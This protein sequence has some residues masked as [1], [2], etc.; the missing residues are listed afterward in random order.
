MFKK[1][2]V[3]LTSLY[4][5]IIMLVSLSF[6]LVIYSGINR[7]LSRIEILE[8]VR[9]HRLQALGLIPENEPS[10]PEIRARI[11]LTLG[12]V[13]LAILGISGLAGY[14]LAGK[15]LEPIEKM[16]EEQ[17]EFVSNASHELRTPL[18]ALKSEIEVSLRDKKMKMP[19]A[20][21][22]L[23]SNLEE[24]NKIQRLTNYLLS[25]NKYQSEISNLPFKNL[26]L[27]E[28]AQKAIKRVEPLAEVKEIRIAK[29]LERAIVN[30]NED[31]L[32]ELATILLDNAIKYSYKKGVVVVRAKKEKGQAVLEVEDNGVGIKKK[33]IPFIFDRFYRA[34]TSRSK[35]KIDGYGLGLS[36]AKNIVDLHVGKIE[37]RSKENK[38]T[39]FQVL[40]RLGI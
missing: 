4:L 22:V 33:D 28:I 19:E 35:G 8:N 1:A 17:K 3:K 5:I 6:S 7:E 29:E 30:G 2:R 20:R 9:A 36:I 34:D 12:L 24:V 21:Q 13:N 40:L 25:L 37:V 11:I 39:T 10:I 27:K 15:T 38:G 18:A 16:H 14:F 23:S 31:S 26:N 32:L